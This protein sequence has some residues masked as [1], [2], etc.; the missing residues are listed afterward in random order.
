MGLLGNRNFTM[1]HLC[2][3]E[4]IVK[5]ERSH[6]N[7]NKGITLIELMV[8]MAVAGIVLMAIYSAY[9]TQSTIYKT[10]NVELNMQQNVRGALY[11]LDREIRMAGYDMYST[12]G[13]GITS[14]SDVNGNS[15]ITFT[16]DLNNDSNQSPNLD[17]AGALDSNE[18][19]SFNMYDSPQTPSIGVFDLAMSIGGSTQLAAE[20]IQALSFAYAY[21]ND[22]DGRFDLSPNGNVI[23]AIDSD[24][25]NDLD[26]RLDTND[27]GEIDISDN[28]AGTSIGGSDVPVGN[29]RAVKAWI[30]ARTKTP[31][32]QYQDNNVYVVGNRR[33]S[34]TALGTRKYKHQ[35]L[36]STINCRNLGME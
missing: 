3:T 34:P 12:G 29:I 36:V 11:L 4:K 17:D 24:G 19:I 35:L 1:N 18:T 6:I 33:I 14:V 13:F 5:S 7:D 10:Q 2:K 22:G 26:R 21:D 15:A 9:H 30:L 8:A 23:W 32:T 16:A 28:P 27:D 25:D 20:S 31:L